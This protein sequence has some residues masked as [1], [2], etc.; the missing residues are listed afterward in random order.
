[1]SRA[2]S[3]HDRLAAIVGAGHVLTG[4]GDLAGYRGDGRGESGG[5]PF[6]V[7]RPSDADQVAALVRLAAKTGVRIVVQGGRT[8]L[9]GAGLASDAGGE[10]IVNL[11]RLSRHIEIDPANR[12]ATLDAGVRLSAL[13]AAAAEHGLFFPIDL[14]ADPS[15]GGMIAA[16]TGGA[17]LLRYGDVR[18]NLR[19]LDYVASDPEGTRQ[20]LGAP[21]WKNNTGL[22]LKQMLVGS[23][24]ATGIVT[25]ATLALQPRPAVRMTAL[26]ALRD[27]EVALTLL[28]ALEAQFGTL[29]S[30]FEGISAAAMAAALDHVAGLRAPFAEVPD[31]AVLIELSAGSAFDENVLEERFAAVLAPLMEGDAAPVSDVAIDHRDRLWAIRHAIPEGLRAKGSVIACDIALRRG[32]VMRCRTAMAARLA[33]EAPGLMPHDFGHIGD[34]GLHYN[35]VWPRAA[36]APDPALIERARTLIFDC[37]VQDYG[38]S[39]SAEHGVGPRNIAHYPRFVPA[40]VRRLAGAVQRLMAPIPLG[41]IDFGMTE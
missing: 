17:P 20:T 5:A 37:V 2:D 18:A 9:V 1:M 8:G 25:R 26:L 30:A 39:F 23:N 15:V 27:P 19:A 3:L 13:N 33:V 7:V 35:L 28:L 34:G 31:Y 4:P 40:G 14:G 41:R 12:T 22:D 36:G 16:N 6:A 11:D 38:G 32:D 29:L 21:V 10:L 24:G